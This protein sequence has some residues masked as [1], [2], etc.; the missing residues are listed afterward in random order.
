MNMTLSRKFELIGG[1][2]TG[3]L[4]I[5]APFCK[6]GAHTFELFKL[7]PGLLLDALVSFVV[8]GVLVAIGSYIHT[9]REKTLGFVMLIVGGIFLIT[10]S[11]I[12]FFGGV[13]FY[14]F[15]L[16]GGVIVLSQSLMAI[17]TVIS[18]L[19]GRSAARDT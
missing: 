2:A 18:S 13:V 8:P 6:N 11:L 17:I 1:V 16:W 19:V 15:G 10:A 14:A 9:R 7:W 12:Y 5:V 4:G 3:V